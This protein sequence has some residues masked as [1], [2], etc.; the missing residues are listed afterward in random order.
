MK[1]TLLG[2]GV[3]PGAGTPAAFAALIQSELAKWRGVA[4]SAGI[5]GD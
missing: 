2:Q 3:Q 4:K 5:T 1:E